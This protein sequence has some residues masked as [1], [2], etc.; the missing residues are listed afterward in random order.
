MKN[1]EDQ[2]D[3]IWHVVANVINALELVFFW[4]QNFTSFQQKSKLVQFIQSFFSWPKVA[5]L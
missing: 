5:T 3:L 2:W 4:G 1:L